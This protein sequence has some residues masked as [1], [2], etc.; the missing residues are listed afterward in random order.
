MT[1][2]ALASRITFASEFEQ[3]IYRDC[4]HDETRK[5]NA[6]NRYAPENHPT[7]IAARASDHAKAVI[8]LMR[9]RGAA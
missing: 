2:P 1:D 3:R 7:R 9:E 8:A 5:V 6:R 4:L